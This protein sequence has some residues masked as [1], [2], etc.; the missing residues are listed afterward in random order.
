MHQLPHFLK[1]AND[2]IKKLIALATSKSCIWKK[3]KNVTQKS[4]LYLRGYRKPKLINL[5]KIPLPSVFLWR[6]ALSFFLAL[7]GA[8]RPHCAKNSAQIMKCPRLW[9]IFE[10]E[11]R[12][13][14]R[15][16]KLVIRGTSASLWL[17]L[18][19]TPLGTALIDD[20]RP[21]D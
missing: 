8:K 5:I 10:S 7:L 17:P 16:I 20:K 6:I 15:V 2:S 11:I 13:T 14:W 12:E 21:P 9:L 1:I 4:S 18:Y 3:P 19:I